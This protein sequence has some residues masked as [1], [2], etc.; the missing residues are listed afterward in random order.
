MTRVDGFVRMLL[1]L[2]C[3]VQ[4][5]A[6]KDDLGL[7]GVVFECVSQE[8][9]ATGYLCR[10]DGS[11]GRSV[12]L[13]EGSIVEPVEGLNLV[14]TSEAPVAGPL[15]AVRAVF[16][17]KGGA[18]LLRWPTQVSD[19]HTSIAVSA[20]FAPVPGPANWR[21]DRATAPFAEGTT[22]DALVVGVTATG[23]A[24]L[25]MGKLDFSSNQPQTVD[26]VRVA[27]AC[28]SDKDGFSDCGKLGCCGG[29]DDS[30]LAD[31]E[32]TVATA[33][34]FATED[35]CTQCG[36]GI[37]QD[38]RGGD[39]VCV[40]DDKDGVPDCMEGACGAGDPKVA[41]GLPEV[42]DGI[43]QDCDDQ[44]DEGFGIGEPCGE[45]A[46]AGGVVVCSAGGLT[47]ECSSASKASA[48]ICG[49]AIDDD[50][51]G[52]TDEG[53]SKHD[54]D[55]DGYGADTG[56]CNDHDAGVF[57]GAPEPCCPRAL[58][59]QPGALVT[60]DKN[61][62]HGV[63]FCAKTDLDEDGYSPPDDCDDGD[64]T[65][66]PGAPERCGDGVDQ[67]CDGSD[68]SCGGLVDVDGDGYAADVDCDDNDSARHPG[69]T[70][71]CDGIDQDC[72]GQTDEGNPGTNG[73]EPCGEAAGACVPGKR[74]CVN[75]PSADL[76]PG[77]IACIG[78][79]GP[80]D[81]A[82]N[83]IDDDCDGETDEAFSVGGQV[84]GDVCDGGGA[85]GE[86]VVECA[87]AQAARCS[88]SPGGSQGGG[89]GEETCNGIDDDCDGTVD[90]GLT[91]LAASDCSLQGVCGAV[92]ADGQPLARA[93]CRVD[94]DPPSSFG[95]DCDYSAIEGY[96]AEEVGGCDGLDNDCDGETDDGL[97][98]GTGCDGDDEDLCDNGVLV[99]T[100]DGSAVFCDE[101]GAATAVESCD[102]LDNDCDGDIDEDFKAGGSISFDGGL[103]AGD[104][105]KW[106]GEGCGTGRCAGGVIE[107]VAGSPQGLKCS[108]SSLA[109]VEKCN[110]VDD[111][112]DG[113]TDETFPLGSNCGIGVCTGGVVECGANGGTRCSTM[114]AGVAQGQPGSAS[115]ATAEVCNNKDDDCDGKSDEDLTSVVDA[116]CS[117]KGVC[118]GAGVASAK[119]SAGTWT[120]S[121][122]SADYQASG[123]L[124]RCDLLDN[125]CDGET[126]EEFAAG[127]T[128]V[129]PLPGGGSASLGETCGVGA[130][131]G[132][133][134]VCSPGGG[135]LVCTSADSS[136]PEICNGVDDDCDGETDE[137]VVA[138]S[139]SQCSIVGV[140]GDAG[141]ATVQCIDGK[142]SCVYGGPTYQAGGEAGLCDDLDNDCDGGTDEDF[143]PGG[144]VWFEGAAGEQLGLGE[145]CGVGACGGGVVQCTADGA[146]LECA[147][148]GV[149]TDDVCNGI[150]DDCDGI[151]DGPFTQGGVVSFDGGPYSADAG[152]VLADAC[153]TGKC[154]GGV[155]VCA[156][157]TALTCDT[158][159][160]AASE[161]CNAVDDDCDGATDEDFMAGGG[162]TYDGG[163]FAGDAGK[164][165]GQACGV[166]ACVG[167]VVVC[168]ATDPTKLT[169]ST[170]AAAAPELCDNV[171]NDCDGMTDEAFK[172]G[173]TV[174]YDGGPL[175]AQG[176]RVLGE[177]CGTGGCAGGTVICD[178]AKPAALTCSSLKL[179]KPESCDG[180]DQDCD[181]ETDEDFKPAKGLI[182]W[183]QPYPPFGVRFLG[184]MC[185]TGKCKGGF[186]V[187]SAAGGLECP[188]MTLAAPDDALSC[189]DVD[190]D[191]DGTTDDAFS[192]GGS[193]TF[194]DWD[195][196][197][198]VKGQAC[199]R[200]ACAGKVACASGSALRCDGPAPTADTSC[201]GVDQ[202]CDGA[203]DEDFVGAPCDS[204]GDGCFRGV[205]LCSAG[206]ALCD[207]DSACPAERPSCAQ[208][209]PGTI[210]QCE[211]TV[212]LESG[213]SCTAALGLGWIC[214]IADGACHQ[215]A[216]P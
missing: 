9:C 4:L 162:Q 17:A 168:S 130:C 42:C 155:V 119:C 47:T 175:P 62:D 104:A 23:T 157:T 150:D 179:A 126:D 151:T 181:G 35:P 174:V 172:A 97:E 94:P 140:C 195:G 22:V 48:E 164:T 142:E 8:D 116:G 203:T 13:T 99:C 85:C 180:T 64:A 134:V 167:G 77:T 44:T 86:G 154:G 15:T 21:L 117:T 208:D 67:D 198:R 169:C 206:E 138:G 166:G 66:Y 152:A 105:G 163:P 31:C 189:N 51:D 2:A 131:Q 75:G 93:T 28:D 139:I 38:C 37:D 79:I 70:E 201:D 215:V 14:V 135:A 188:T 161:Q 53:C 45:G 103:F 18:E 185:G 12:C 107:C 57:P 212:G 214:S 156:G 159:A 91:D 78:G 211:C 109:V 19:V 71:L 125:D 113:E 41:P 187:C 143:L 58:Q 197:L 184:E 213:D 190:D 147:E 128:V 54:L 16:A 114:P 136:Q 24:T 92:D 90:E 69:A 210:D 46:C 177:S 207:G 32:P 96:S 63:K 52:G 141:T 34:P 80:V 165:L 43:D 40:D 120:C 10:V 144:S 106:L 83:G 178:A 194:V 74:V 112:C 50:C 132:G 100:E 26:L 72:D 149:G 118:G 202:D 205:S 199:G 101:S 108:T 60:C 123:E 209:A 82:C 33:N 196:A 192:A 102:G 76:A 30:V 158:L 59:G 171:D 36:D 193:V 127:G 182:G 146:G 148:G 170:L 3:L 137:D 133:T 110:G 153:G 115:K 216:G 95:W 122:D 129:L 25:W 56:D 84:V 11:L 191:C 5:Q 200:G 39:A 121:F 65:V 27:A 124:G 111:D 73:G 20:S 87:S 98:L 81:E 160:S 88:T 173:G 183:P 176:G 89:A 29:A 7:G 145:S 68:L 61:C 55:G 49:N 1:A 204:G 6:C 186:V